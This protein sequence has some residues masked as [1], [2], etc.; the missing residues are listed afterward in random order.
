M[1]ALTDFQM[2]LVTRSAGLLPNPHDRCQY[3]RSIANRL[4]GA[5]NTTDGDIRDAI[6]FVLGCSGVGGGSPS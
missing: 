5:A 1:L 2:D 3:L 6:D 4:G